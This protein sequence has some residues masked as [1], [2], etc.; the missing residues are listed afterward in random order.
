MLSKGIRPLAFGVSKSLRL[1]RTG[2]AGLL[3]SMAGYRVWWRLR[4][5]DFGVVNHAELGLDPARASFHKDGGGPQLGRLLR[6]LT[7]TA[8]DSALDLGSGKGGAMATLARYPFR[9]VDGVEISPALVDVARR[10]LGKLG[11]R[12]CHVFLGDATEFH[13]LDDYNVVFMFHPFSEEV[14]A[15]V[16]ANLLA[17]LGRRPR[18]LRIVYSNPAPVEEMILGSGRFDREFDYRPYEDFRIAVYANADGGMS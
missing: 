7:I 18:R 10:N 2:N 1:I 12:Q 13:D 14:F 11:L 17:S 15:E 9:R 8:S 6:R 5:L 3:L 16:L 4:G